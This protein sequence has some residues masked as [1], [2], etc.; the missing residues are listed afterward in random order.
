M[1]HLRALLRVP[2]FAAVTISIYLVFLVGLLPSS[3]LKGGRLAW[4]NRVITFWGVISSGLLSLRIRVE[5]SVPQ[6]PFYL[7]CNHLSYLDILPLY[8]TLDCTF[9]AMKEVA[10]WPVIGFMAKTLGVIFID[11]TRKTDVRRVN[12]EVLES[13]GKFQGVVIFPEG[14]TSGG[15]H[16][17]PFKASLLKHPAE[18]DLPVHFAAISYRT[19]RGDPP[20]SESVCW[21]RGVSFGKHAWGL[22][23]NRE[24]NCTLRFG[25]KTFDEKDRKRLALLLHREVSALYESLSKGHK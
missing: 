9:V 25:K 3:L 11:R 18:S 8:R 5:G 7:I 20:P 13:V 16:V 24:I 2:L 12:L 6:A 19:G 22:A 4:R 15:S 14:G 21:G 10:S 17:L 1:K 23:G